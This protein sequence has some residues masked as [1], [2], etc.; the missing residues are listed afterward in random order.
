MPALCGLTGGHCH[1]C[2]LLLEAVSSG[3]MLMGVFRQRMTR[4][5]GVVIIPTLTACRKLAMRLF[6]GGKKGSTMAKLAW[7]GGA[8]LVFSPPTSAVLSSCYLIKLSLLY[9]WTVLTLLHWRSVA[10]Q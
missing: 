4:V 5:V 1:E 2:M 6:F 9:L 7:Y 8:S 10:N 3:T